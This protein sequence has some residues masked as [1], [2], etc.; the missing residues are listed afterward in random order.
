MFPS[1]AL[2]GFHHFTT[3]R[4]LTQ[5]FSFK[6][7]TSSF[8]SIPPALI[9]SYSSFTLTSCGQSVFKSRGRP[10]YTTQ[11]F[12]KISLIQTLIAFT[13]IRFFLLTIHTFRSIDKEYFIRLYTK[14][15]KH[16]TSSKKFK[17]QQSVTQPIIGSALLPLPHSNPFTQNLTIIRRQTPPLPSCHPPPAAH[18]TSPP[19]CR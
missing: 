18:Q 7:F 15:Q 10:T 2:S 5:K 19:P 17:G 16:H 8:H 14:A 13:K 12:I 9:F 6:K 4:S 1:S 11:K 3:F